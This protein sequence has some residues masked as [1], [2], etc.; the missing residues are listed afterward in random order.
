MLLFGEGFSHI[1]IKDQVPH[2]TLI[3]II[4]EFGLVGTPFLAMWIIYFFRDTYGSGRLRRDQL[5][6]ILMVA[7]GAFLPWMALD[8]L[9]FNE[10]FLFQMY[11]FVALQEMRVSAPRQLS[12]EGQPM[13][14][15]RHSSIRFVW[16]S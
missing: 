10:F 5:F 2:N 1:A 4:Y 3:Q 11:V 12:P 6:N 15:P 8:I 9:Y 14:S 7:T 13:A 16:R